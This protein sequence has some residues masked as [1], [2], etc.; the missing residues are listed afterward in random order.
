M[1]KFKRAGRTLGVTVNDLLDSQRLKLSVDLYKNGDD[2]ALKAILI[3]LGKECLSVAKHA[4]IREAGRNWGLP[5]YH[6]KPVLTRFDDFQ[7]FNV[8]WSLSEP[9]VKLYLAQVNGAP[10]EEVE[11][12]VKKVAEHFG[13]KL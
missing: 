3:E 2:S 7:T 12:L 9:E 11:E 8:H 5:F 4:T 10:K 13:V 6:A 1:S